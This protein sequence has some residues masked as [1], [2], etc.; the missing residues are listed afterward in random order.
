MT[1][2]AIALLGGLYRDMVRKENVLRFAEE[3]ELLETY[4]KIMQLRYPDSFGY[5]IVLDSE[6]LDVKTPKFWASALGRKFL[7]PWV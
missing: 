7:F 2:D 5:Q 1:A 6:L 4:L 3:K